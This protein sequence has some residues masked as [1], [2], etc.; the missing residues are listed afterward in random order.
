MLSGVNELAPTVG[1]ARACDVLGVPRSS[2]YH[3]QQPATARAAPRPHPPSPRALS[4]AECAQIREVLNSERFVDRAPRTVYAILLDEGRYL[5]SWRTMYRILAA[6]AATRERRELRQHPIYAR[7]ELLATAPGQVWSWDITKLRGPLPGLW[8]NLYVIL[9]I[10]SRKIVGWLIAE[11]EDA[12]LAELLIAESCAREGIAPQQLTLHA[13][14]GAPMTSKTVA[15]LLID[16]GVARS[17]SRPRVSNDNPYS[18]SQFK[19]MKYD[20]S[21]PDR[22]ASI[23]EA[24]TWM[25]EFVAWYNTEHR[26]SGIGLLTPEMVHRGQAPQQVAARQ[27]V[28]EGAYA[29]HPERFVRGR[30]SPPLVPTAV[31]INLPHPSS[32][33]ATPATPALQPAAAAASRVSAA[34]AAP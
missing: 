28:L 24:R 8:Y 3:A 12:E 1:I 14:R 9:D 18:E 11:H 31:G 27:T 15:E 25:R 2:F 33:A 21:Y 26:H 6:D 19:T 32:V 30:P 16:L 29:V 4:A 20:P 22:F 34:A 10:F 13:D 5:C 23:E 17:H 7:P